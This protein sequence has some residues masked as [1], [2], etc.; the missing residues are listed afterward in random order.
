MAALLDLNSLGV[1]FTSALGFAN[2][3]CA[4]FW[5]HFAHPVTASSGFALGY[6]FAGCVVT[7]LTSVLANHSAHF[8]TNFSGSA[9]GHHLA[10]CVVANLGSILTNHAANLVTNFLG[11]ALRDHSAN[12]VVAGFCAAL[13][14]HFAH[15]IGASSGAALRHNTANR[16]RD[17]TSSTFTPILCAA[18]FFLLARWNPNSLA[19][20]LWRAL[21][22]FGA[23]FARHVNALASA[24]VVS[25]SA[26]LT[27][28]LFHDRAGDRLG[29]RFP[30]PTLNSHGSCVLFRDTNTVL[31]CSHF[32]FTNSIVDGVVYLSCF[33]FVDWFA[34]G[35]VY[36]S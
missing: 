36:R 9:L 14:Y 1:A 33:G 21:H 8:V 2:R 15:A 20:R 11:S 27:N 19:N 26:R 12:C 13:R 17:L 10:C 3:T 6:H 23:A 34:Y 7:N 25:P 35:V 32:L 4:A 5:N 16:V 31:F 24:R 29:L 18:N 28:G 30:M 22:A